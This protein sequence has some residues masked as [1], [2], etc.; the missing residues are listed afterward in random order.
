MEIWKDIEGYE[1]FY[2]ISNYGR[3]KSLERIVNTGL[4][5]IRK[6]KETILK[7]PIKRGYYQIRLCKN[8]KRKCYQVHRLVANAF[9]ENPNNFPQVNHKD[10]NKLNNIYTNLE[11]CSVSYNN[12]YGTRLDRVIKKN[13]LRREVI[14]YDIDGNYI[15]EYLSVSEAARQNKTNPSCICSCCQGKIKTS[16]GYVYKY[17]K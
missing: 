4:K 5:A 9:I 13:K 17:K 14:K 7:L 15:A 12:T 10:E 8:G 2:R 3:I 6:Q 1:G 11:W 16:K